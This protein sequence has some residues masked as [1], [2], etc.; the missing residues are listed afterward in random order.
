MQSTSWD[1]ADAEDLWVVHRDPGTMRFVR[2]GRPET[3]TETRELVRG[4]IDQHAQ[5]GWTRWRVADHEG[6]LVGRAGF[7][8]H[9]HGTEVAY[10]IGREF[11]GRGL[12]TEAC[13][14]LLTWHCEHPELFDGDELIAH[15]AVHNPGSVRVLEK[16]GF[17]RVGEVDVGGVRCARFRAPLGGQ[18]FSDADS[19]IR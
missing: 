1:C 18:V 17:S 14:A 4:Y 10:T 11:W 5:R 13:R 8:E 19:L 9:G 2:A 6:R 7:T 3:L 12:A 15:A 16:S